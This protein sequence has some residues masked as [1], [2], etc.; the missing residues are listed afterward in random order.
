M[1]LIKEAVDG[2]TDDNVDELA[3]AITTSSSGNGRSAA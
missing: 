2:P 1:S 3:D